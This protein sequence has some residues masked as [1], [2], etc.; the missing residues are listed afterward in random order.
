MSKYLLLG[1]GNSLRTDDGAGSFIAKTFKHDNWNVLD[2]RTAPENFT[3]VVKKDCPELLVIVDSVEM[4]LPAGSIRLIPLEKIVTLQFST[5]YMSLSYLIEYLS[6]YCQKIV[7]IGIQPLSTE[8]GE[9]LSKPVL[10]ACYQVIDL[11]KNN[12]L[13]DIPLLS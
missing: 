3:S 11:L 5:H 12:H 1:I 9:N 8:M 6:P 2:G 13:N 4:D 7:L 10:K